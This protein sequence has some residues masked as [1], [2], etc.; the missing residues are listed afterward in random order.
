MLAHLVHGMYF[1]KCPC[2]FSSAVYILLVKTIQ[3]MYFMDLVCCVEMNHCSSM[4]VKIL[5]VHLS[6]CRDSLN[7]VQCNNVIIC[8]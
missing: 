7:A 5:C 1:S 6:V 8:I 2:I 3:L 4:Y